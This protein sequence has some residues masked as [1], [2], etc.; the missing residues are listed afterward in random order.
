M[1]LL[2]FRGINGLAGRWWLVDEFF[3]LAANDYVVPSVIVTLLLVRWFHPEPRHRRVVVHAIVA[4]LLAN[5]LVKGLNLLW[6]RP[7]PFTYNEV[8]LLFY[9]PS[10]SSFPSNSAAAV[11]SLAAAL[12]FRDRRG[13]TGRIALALAALMGLSRIWIGVHYPLDIVGGALIGLVAAAGVEQQRHRLRPLTEAL[14]TIARR[15]ALA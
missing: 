11:W 12:W 7:R 8:T 14:H 13:A 6:F 2:L 1:D 15:L 9:F 10:D 5:L 4:L 3:R